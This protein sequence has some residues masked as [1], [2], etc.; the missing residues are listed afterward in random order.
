MAIGFE[1]KVTSLQRIGVANRSGIDELPWRQQYLLLENVRAHFSTRIEEAMD[2]SHHTRSIMS[3]SSN[4]STSTSSS[5]MR[6]WTLFHCV[7]ASMALSLIQMAAHPWLA[8]RYPTIQ[9]K[10]TSRS[11]SLRVANGSSSTPQYHHLPPAILDAVVQNQHPQEQRLD[12]H[13]N[14]TTPQETTLPTFAHPMEYKWEGIEDMRYFAQTFFEGS[15]IYCDRIQQ[16]RQQYAHNSSQSSFSMQ[17]RLPLLRLTVSFGCAELFHKSGYGTG[18]YLSLLYALRLAT[19]VNDNISLNLTC[20]DA[21]ATK[22]DLIVPWLTGYQPPRVSSMQHHPAQPYPTVSPSDSCAS[23]H[24]SPIAAM[25]PDMQY[26]LRRM[27]L[28]LVGIDPRHSA[29]A[30]WAKQHDLVSPH[31]DDTAAYQLHVPVHVDQPVYRLGQDIAPLDDAV[32]HF[33]CGDLM[34]SKH[35]NFAFVRF[36]SY[37]RHIAPNTT[38]IGILTQPFQS[39]DNDQTR[40]CDA[41]DTTLDRCRTVVLALVD[42]L[43]QRHPHARITIHNG[44][45]ETIALAYARMILARQTLAGL[46]TFGIFPVLATFG[47]AYLHQ[48][49]GPQFVNGWLFRDA[50]HGSSNVNSTVIAAAPHVHL[51][52]EDDYI[53]VAD[54]KRKWETHGAKDVVAWFR[55]ENVHNH[56]QTVRSDEATDESNQ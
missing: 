54:I 15:N 29:S 17:Q 18:N 11:T 40:P 48:P 24:T 32:I 33:R 51:T 56:D 16:E 5:S 38:S 52:Y 23:Y 46:S 27:A 22:G 55:N 37:T 42:Y 25:I 1:S 6:R 43:Q 28:G 35:P 53:M 41:T 47:T 45:H 20:H 3:S 50:E 49:R 44:P 2:H 34:D 8:V 9:R 36:E 31:N 21:D 14:V 39:R 13:A 26:D 30:T 10:N 12:E 4:N 19:A 7:V